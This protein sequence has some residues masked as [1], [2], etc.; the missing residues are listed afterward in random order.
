MLVV[1]RVLCV[2]NRADCGVLW[3]AVHA[4]CFVLRV[5]TVACCVCVCVCVCV[6]CIELLCVLCVVCVCVHVCGLILCNPTPADFVCSSV[7]L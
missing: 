3:C 5:V 7:P 2:L 4:V 1:S 6:L